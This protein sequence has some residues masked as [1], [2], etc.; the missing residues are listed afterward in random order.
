MENKIE[1]IVKSILSEL[2]GN[3][4][5][6]SFNTNK[7]YNSEKNI[8]TINFTTINDKLKTMFDAKTSNT[9]NK[10]ITNDFVVILDNSKQR[11]I[12]KN[13]SNPMIVFIEQNK[14]TIIPENC[15]KVNNE[16]GDNKKAIN[17]F[18]NQ[19]NKDN[20]ELK[21]KNY[22][23]FEIENKTNKIE[24]KLVFHRELDDLGEEITIKDYNYNI[25]NTSHD[26]Y[27]TFPDKTYEIISS[28]INNIKKN[29]ACSYVLQINKENDKLK[30]VIAISENQLPGYETIKEYQ[31]E[32][33]KK[34][35]KKH[36]EV[37]QNVNDN[38]S[39]EPI[40]ETKN[41]FEQNETNA[42]ANCN[43]NDLFKDCC[44]SISTTLSDWYTSIKSKIFG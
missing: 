7:E 27:L 42:I 26:I 15:Q 33:D 5:A 38:L 17:I 8:K 34:A 35:E 12:L 24:P 37:L 29:K 40:K 19:L 16:D 30:P 23:S 6:L 28:S 41:I 3:C 44:N 32:D 1:D 36:K 43:C 39:L 18:F 9:E 14:I 20:N 11:I 10:I 22:I 4:T 31:T 2:I 13:Q 21:L 25:S